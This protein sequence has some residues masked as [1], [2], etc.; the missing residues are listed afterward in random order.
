MRGVAGVDEEVL[1]AGREATA[2]LAALGV[3][4]DHDL[5]EEAGLAEHLVHQQ[6]QV[7]DLVVVDADED[8]A[9]LGQHPRAASS[10]GRIIATQASC[11]V[12][13]AAGAVRK[14]SR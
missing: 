11:R 12:A 13:G 2:E 5:G 1:V 8:R 10:R 6:P 3:E 9:G 4:V 7:R 14:S